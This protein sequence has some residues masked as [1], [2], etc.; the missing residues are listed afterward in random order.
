[1]SCQEIASVDAELHV[2]A[3]DPYS[4]IYVV[5]SDDPDFDLSTVTAAAFS[6]RRRSDEA[7]VSWTAALSGASATEITLTHTFEAGDLTV[8]GLY[9]FIPI[10]TTPSGNFYVA[11]R[12]IKVRDPFEMRS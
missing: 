1:M 10:L 8:A 2:G 9:T 5:T 4:L 12:T 7:P 6:V 11:S 3:V